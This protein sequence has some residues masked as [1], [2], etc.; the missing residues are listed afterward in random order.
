MEAYAEEL[1]RPARKPVAHS[2]VIADGV[3]DIWA[4]D[5]AE[6]PGWYDENDGY[7]YILVVVDVFSRYAW[8]IALQTKNA[9]DVWDAFSIALREHKPNFIWVD[10]GSEFYNATWTSRLKGLDV[11]R[12]STYGGMYKVSIAERFIRTLKHRIW[13]EFVRDNT[14]KWI[15]RLDEIVDEYNNTIHSAIRMTPIEAR[16]EDNEDKLYKAMLP[17][18]SV[19]K[20]KFSLGEWVRI[21]RAKDKFEKGF[22]PNWSYEIYKIVSIKLTSPVRYYLVDYYGEEIE[23]A[24]YENELQ[25]VSDP[26]FFPVEKV[27]KQRTYKGRKEKLVKFLGYKE[28]RW[29]P[30]EAVSDL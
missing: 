18:T 22:H 10:K 30:A 4:M 1:M 3:D 11:G 8:C 6:M 16:K 21:S 27:L 2:K 20:P 23:G 12:Y 25:Q 13:F 19:G 17:P 24:F 7:K 9:K 28:P 5:I 29:M 26:S 15:D 14:R